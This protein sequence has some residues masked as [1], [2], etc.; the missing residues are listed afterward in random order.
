M[1]G[2]SGVDVF[3]ISAKIQP[4]F[5]RKT[6]QYFLHEASHFILRTIYR[7]RT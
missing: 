1:T 5:V 6:Y 3:P 2:V 7:R 4:T